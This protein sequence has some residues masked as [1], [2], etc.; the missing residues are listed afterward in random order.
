VLVYD[1]IVGEASRVGYGSALAVILVVISIVPI[2][3]FVW[4]AFKETDLA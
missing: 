4:N 3:V 1:N 2:T